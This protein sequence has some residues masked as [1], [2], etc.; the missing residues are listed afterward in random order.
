MPRVVQVARVRRGSPCRRAGPRRARASPSASRPRGRASA[1]GA[2][3]DDGQG[4]LREQAHVPQREHGQQ[5]VSR[6]AGTRTAGQAS[7]PR[8]AGAG[9][10]TTRPRSAPALP[11][12]LE[13]GHEVRASAAGQ[14]LHVV[15]AD[16]RDGACG[17]P[18]VSV[19][20]G[21]RAPCRRRRSGSRP[22][23]PAAGRWAGRVPGVAEVE[24]GPARSCS[25][26]TVLR[27]GQL[28]RRAPTRAPRASLERPPMGRP[29]DQARAAAPPSRRRAKKP[30]PPPAATAST[31]ARRTSGSS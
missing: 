26:M 17:S 6:S 5:E 27:L 29:V 11:L 31:Q 7:P 15:L 23:G 12:P 18:P 8:A 22:R 9:H 3:D 28:A 4:R 30:S 14:Q 10:P 25:S 2:D 20:G 1:P 13:D 24:H 16:A 21:A 19:I